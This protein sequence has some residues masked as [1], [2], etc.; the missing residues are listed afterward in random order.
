[1]GEGARKEENRLG[2]KYQESLGNE[3][4]LMNFNKREASK[5]IVSWNLL[6]Q[7]ESLGNDCNK[8]KILLPSVVEG[9]RVKGFLS[10]REEMKKLKISQVEISHLLSDQRMVYQL[11]KRSNSS[12]KWQLDQKSM[13]QRIYSISKL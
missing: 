11:R 13:I 6:N 7:V 12:L 2:I 10:I 8:E 5:R 1:M 3:C 9:Q 4:I